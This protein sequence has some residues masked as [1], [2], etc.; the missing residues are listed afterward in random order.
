M[1]N[2][3]YVIGSL[4]CFISVLVVACAVGEQLG[5]V[6]IAAYFSAGLSLGYMFSEA[7]K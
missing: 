3:I 7:V 1:K 5:F 2:K 4:V 6:R